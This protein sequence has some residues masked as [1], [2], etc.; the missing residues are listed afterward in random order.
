MK[1]ID[2]TDILKGKV[3]IIG[4]GNALKGDDA[5]GPALVGRIAG[6]TRAVTID[7]GSA[8]ENH[9]RAITRERPDTILIV[10]A[11]D[12]DGQAGEAELLREEDIMK[13]GFSTH[14]I[15]PHLFIQYLA[16]ETGADI[17][18]LG[19]QPKDVA[20]GSGISEP[21]MRALDD[22]ERLLVT[23]LN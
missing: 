13:G 7:A 1:R 5:L 15:S 22:I 4:V 10:D 16:A 19:V 21:V 14:T 8:P 17:Y 12:L 6:R 18:L 3:V 2:V 20:F 9:T 23:A 11:V